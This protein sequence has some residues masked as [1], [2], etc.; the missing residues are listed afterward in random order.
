MIAILYRIDMS[1]LRGLRLLSRFSMDS[2]PWLNHAAP[3]P[4]GVAFSQTFVSLQLYFKEC[5]RCEF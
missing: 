3:R 4:D 2:R 1:L 5:L